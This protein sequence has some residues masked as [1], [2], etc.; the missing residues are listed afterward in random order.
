MCTNLTGLYAISQGDFLKSKIERH[1]F[2]ASKNHTFLEF[3]KTFFF[4]GGVAVVVS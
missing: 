3:E 1:N 2:E 4:E